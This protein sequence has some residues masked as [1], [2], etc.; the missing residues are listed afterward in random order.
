MRNCWWKMDPIH[1]TDKTMLF[2]FANEVAQKKAK[3]M[4][5]S[6]NL[7]GSIF[8]VYKELSTFHSI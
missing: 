8:F 7:I 3:A 6:G 5:P 2:F 1:A 4:K